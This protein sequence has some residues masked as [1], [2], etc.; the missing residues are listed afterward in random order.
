MIVIIEN[1]NMFILEVKFFFS[2]M[3]FHVVP[4]CTT[5]TKASI[6]FTDNNFIQFYQYNYYT[7]LVKYMQLLSTEII[8]NYY[9]YNS[10]SEKTYCISFK[11][12][13]RTEFTETRITL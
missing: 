6:I 1:E 5:L 9:H 13:E 4:P 2:L 3:L 10:I 8:N 11:I 7:M 12:T